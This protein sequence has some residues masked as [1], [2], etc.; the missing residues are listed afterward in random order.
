MTQ[1]YSALLRLVADIRYNMDKRKLTILLH[2]DF[3]K[4]FDTILPSRLLKVMEKMRFSRTALF[5]FDVR[6]DTSELDRVYIK[7]GFLRDQY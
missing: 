1:Y 2:F 7:F 5:T 4:A 6:I 3:P